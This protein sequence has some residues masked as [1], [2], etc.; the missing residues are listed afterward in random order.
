MEEKQNIIGEAVGQAVAQVQELITNSGFIETATRLQ[1]QL[2]KSNEINA[3]AVSI[4]TGKNDANKEGQKQ[5]N[6]KKSKIPI[7]INRRPW[8]SAVTIYENAVRN[9]MKRISSS[10]DDADTSDDIE[11][12]INQNVYVGTNENLIN[13]F[14]TGQ[15]KEF[16]DRRRV[17]DGNRQ[18]PS[19]SRAE[20]LPDNRNDAELLPPGPDDMANQMIKQAEATRANIFTTPGES[21]DVAIL[22]KLV[23]NIPSLSLDANNVFMHS[24]MVDENYLVLGNH[25]DLVTKQKIVL[26]EYIDFSKLL[27]KD[28]VM[29]VEQHGQKMEMFNKDGQMYWV[30]AAETSK[31]NNFS[32]WEQAF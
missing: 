19:T 9:S 16:E 15:R 26:G 11:E 13:Q 10:S 28:W 23:D 1:Q 29:A 22:N 24:A 8:V 17:V 12:Y 2:E 25:V 5:G 27:P 32:K 31:I 30:P 21:N 6:F 3:R 18:I 20:K 7:P 14:I 4:A